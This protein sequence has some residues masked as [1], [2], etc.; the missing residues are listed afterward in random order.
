MPKQ[1]LYAYVDESGQDTEGLL[2]VVGIVVLEEE[3]DRLSQWLEKLEARTQK[4]PAKW[5]KSRHEFRQAYVEAL[6]AAPGLSQRIFVSLFQNTRQYQELTALTTAKAVLKRAR[7]PYKVTIFVD[8]LSATA[9]V[10]FTRTLRGLHIQTRKVRGVRKE[11][12]SALIRLADAVCGLVRDFHEQVPWAVG[13]FEA[14]KAARIVEE[15]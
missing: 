3:R 13:A 6:A 8:G 9:V 7:P 12:S 11:E 14:L 1:N 2:F 4:G 10:G 5:H 15:I